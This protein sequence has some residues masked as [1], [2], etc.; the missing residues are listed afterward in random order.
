MHV[1]G[2]GA[3]G[4]FVGVGVAVSVEVLVW[5]VAGVM[6]KGGTCRMVSGRKFSEVRQFFFRSSS[7]ERP[8]SW[9]IAARLSPSFSSSG[10]H[11]GGMAQVWVGVGVAVSEGMGEGVNVGAPGGMVGR[12][13]AVSVNVGDNNPMPVFPSASARLRTPRRMIRETNPANSPAMIWRT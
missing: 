9:A 3:T 11:P 2:R 13:E 7:R 8:R 10:I 6:V 12:G 1:V 4:V 5:V